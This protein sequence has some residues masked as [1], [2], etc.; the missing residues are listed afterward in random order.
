M[1]RDAAVQD[2]AGYWSRNMT[3]QLTHPSELTLPAATL[4]IEDRAEGAT[5]EDLVRAWAYVIRQ[6]A[7]H[8]PDLAAKGYAAAARDAVTLGWVSADG[9]ILVTFTEDGRIDRSHDAARDFT[10]FGHT[11]RQD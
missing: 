3:A 1:A 10:L 4:I 2:C 6:R 9:D 7:H 8:Y 11:E 5:E